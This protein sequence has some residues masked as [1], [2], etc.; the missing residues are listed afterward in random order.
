MPPP[1]GGTG[2]VRVTVRSGVRCVAESS[3]PVPAPS[4]LALIDQ[5]Q[6][7]HL[8]MTAWP[9]AVP[10][11][12]HHAK[13]L[14]WDVGYKELIEPVELVVSE[15]V[16]NA[17]RVSGGLDKAQP[18]DGAPRPVIRLWLLPE[19]DSVLVL[20][21][22]GCPG[23]PQRQEPGLEADT[24]RGLWLVEMHSTAWGSFTITD[25]P[26]KVVWALCQI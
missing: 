18:E 8:E 19:Q 4:S 11:S 3:T 13:Q 21:W 15:L 22:D 16:T 14:L 6:Q 7:P 10:V 20:V 12:R 25:I 1:S 23:L 24:G 17:V 26:G 9:G 5:L 2:T